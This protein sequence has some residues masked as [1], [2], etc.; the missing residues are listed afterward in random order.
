MSSVLNG[1]FE[2]KV[3]SVLNKDAKQFGKKNM[4]D[5]NDETCWNSDQ[6]TPQFISIL[7]PTEEDIDKIEIQFQGGFVGQDCLF[8]STRESGEKNEDVPFYPED[9]NSVQSFPLS[10]IVRAK[11]FTVVFNKSTDFFGRIVIY[12]FNAYSPS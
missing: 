9:V 6:G 2:C 7:L 10:K 3:S 1:N 5:N 12:K 11:K 4:F 8:C